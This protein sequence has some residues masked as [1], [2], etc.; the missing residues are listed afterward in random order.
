MIVKTLSSRNESGY[1]KRIDKGITED[2]TTDVLQRFGVL[3]SIALLK[4]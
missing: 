1:M 2:M 3:T 4:Q